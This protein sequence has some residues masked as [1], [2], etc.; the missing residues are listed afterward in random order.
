[1]RRFVALVARFSSAKTCRVAKTGSGRIS[2]GNRG[3]FWLVVVVF[4]AFTMAYA[5]R[6]IQNTL[7]LLNAGASTTFYWQ[8]QDDYK[9]WGANQAPGET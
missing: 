3:L 9:S 4:S 5:A 7:A 1:M 2:Q 8:V 6:T